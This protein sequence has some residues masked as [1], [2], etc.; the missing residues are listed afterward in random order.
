MLVLFLSRRMAKPQLSRAM[1]AVVL[2]G[3]VQ[4]PKESEQ[5]QMSGLNTSSYRST[6]ALHCIVSA[7]NIV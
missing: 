6:E 5:I 2:C 4:V 1:S 3:S 7:R